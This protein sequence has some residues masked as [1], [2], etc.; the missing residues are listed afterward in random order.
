MIRR[1]EIE[2]PDSPE[3]EAAMKLMKQ[4]EDYYFAMHF[5]YENIPRKHEANYVSLVRNGTPEQLAAFRERVEGMTLA[6]IP[7]PKQLGM[8][9]EA[10]VQMVQS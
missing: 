5:V 6:G 1:V 8:V 4:K 2:S 9:T 3:R 10:I 7:E